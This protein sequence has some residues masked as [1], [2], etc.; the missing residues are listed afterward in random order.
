MVHVGILE[1]PEQVEGHPGYKTKLMYAHTDACQIMLGT[2]IV[3][4]LP[5]LYTRT[6]RAGSAQ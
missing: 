5:S 6:T 1:R 3:S 4:S 2:G